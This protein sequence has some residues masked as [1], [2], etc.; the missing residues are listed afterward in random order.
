MI[1]GHQNQIKFFKDILLKGRVS[2]GYLFEGP[3]MIG[4]KKIAIEFIKGLFC[5]KKRKKF[6]G[7]NTCNSC[8]NIE[9]KNHPN[10]FFI[11]K[12][13]ITISTIRFLRNN[14]NLKSDFYKVVIFDNAHNLNKEASNAFLKTLEE[15]KGE[16]IFILITDKPELL[17]KTISSRLQRIKFFSVNKEELRKIFETRIQKVLKTKQKILIDNSILIDIANG[18]PGFLFKI[19]DN[20]EILEK[21]QKIVNDFFKFLIGDTVEKLNL[22]E[23]YK[24]QNLY[25][26]FNIWALLCHFILMKKINLKK[27]S[28]SFI[29]FNFNK[30]SDGSILRILKFLLKIN[31]LFSSNINLNK[32][33]AFEV[34]ACLI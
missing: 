30:V 21:I 11:E 26:V 8:F 17:L 3:Q 6:G 29:D 18:R 22:L 9:L 7:C 32:K 4:K 13:K 23:N 27:N 25:E 15:P 33:L 24:N 12:E 1:I 16:T 14:L 20:S 28:F 31:A 10:V 2:Q 5:E 19:L 34:L